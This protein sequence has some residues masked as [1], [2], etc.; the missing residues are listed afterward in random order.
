MNN[1]AHKGLKI[2][3]LAPAVL[4]LVMGLRWW[5]DPAGAADALGMPLLHGLGLSSQIGDLAAFFLLI[6]LFALTGIVT[7]AR[8]WFFAPVALL[9]LA[10][11]SRILAWAIQDASLALPM[12]LFELLVASIF[13]FGSGLAGD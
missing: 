12:I 1:L 7:G 6:S 13:W 11:F 10:A 9:L 3:L 5:V 4:F 2:L 8:H